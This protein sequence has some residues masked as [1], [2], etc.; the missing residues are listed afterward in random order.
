MIRAR[1]IAVGCALALIVVAAAGAA[2]QERPAG[3]TA[4]AWAISV[5]VPGR[6]AAGTRS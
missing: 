5:I 3:S 2:P 1:V 4:R 6:P